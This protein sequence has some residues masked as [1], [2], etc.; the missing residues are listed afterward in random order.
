[1]WDRDYTPSQVETVM[2]GWH[3]ECGIVGG[4]MWI[5]DDFVGNGLAKKYASAINTGVE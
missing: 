4:F 5:Y 1:V 2:R 3:D